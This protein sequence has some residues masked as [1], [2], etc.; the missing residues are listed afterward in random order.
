MGKKLLNLE[1]MTMHFADL[2]AVMESEM[3]QYAAIIT[4][5]FSKRK[6]NRSNN[7]HTHVIH[8]DD[9]ESAI[10]EFKLKDDSCGTLDTDYESP[11]FRIEMEVEID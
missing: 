10:E 4:F 5:D 1:K 2:S 8:G 11:V 7:L 6:I 9:L 3:P